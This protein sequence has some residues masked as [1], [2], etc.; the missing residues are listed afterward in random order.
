M[1][2]NHKHLAVL[3]FAGMAF[4]LGTKYVR[5]EEI[6]PLEIAPEAPK[7][8]IIETDVPNDSSSNTEVFRGG[9]P[10][11]LR[12]APLYGYIGSADG[13]QR[14]WNKYSAGITAEIPL[15]P[16]LSIEGVFRYALFDIR[17][18]ASVNLGGV[19]T[20]LGTNYGSPYPSTLNAPSAATII[21]LGD[22]RQLMIGG[23]LKYELFPHSILTPFIGG[24]ISYFDNE[25]ITTDN[26]TVRVTFPQAVYGASALGGMKLK[27]SKEVAI[28]GRTEVGSLL[29]NHNG[30]IF[31]GPDGSGASAH[32]PVSF[33]S[34]DKYW[35]MMAGISFGI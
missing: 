11:G 3:A 35:T 34:Y 21:P 10:L 33:R 24:G 5:A 15:S 27:L 25:Y 29:N 26:P 8:M 17:Q 19:G 4:A 2:L 6:S 28:V 7:K 1:K 30:Q 14:L 9:N 16:N 13:N 20:V 18:S 22:M 12:V 32:P 23:N 31:W